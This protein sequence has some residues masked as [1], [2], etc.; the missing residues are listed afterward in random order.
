MENKNLRF[1][2]I[3]LLTGL[4]RHAINARAKT[5]YD[6]S[7]LKRSPGNQILLGP[8]QVKTLIQDCLSNTKGKVI[9][10]GNL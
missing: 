8:D 4:K 6:S 9:Y 5:I 1:S 2:Q 3:S 10:I 7:Q